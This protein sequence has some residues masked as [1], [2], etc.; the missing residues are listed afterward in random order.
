MAAH[1]D[2]IGLGE[3]DMTR[4]GMFVAL[5]A[6]FFGK[7]A[8]LFSVLRQTA[9]EDFTKYYS[10]VGWDMLRHNFPLTSWSKEKGIPATS[11][12]TIKWMRYE[13]MNGDN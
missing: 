3:K 10:A 5:L 4:R 12:K 11:G 8:K 6:P 9:R 1:T 7:V 13:K 2:T